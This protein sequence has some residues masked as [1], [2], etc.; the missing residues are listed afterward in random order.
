MNELK[1]KTV[2]QLRVQAKQLNEEGI[3]RA[4]QTEIARARKEELIEWLDFIEPED[5]EKTKP[6]EP[7]FESHSQKTSTA[8][9]SSVQF[10]SSFPSHELKADPKAVNKES[11]ISESPDRKLQTVTKN[12]EVPQGEMV[13][14]FLAGSLIFFFIQ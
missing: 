11:S 7:Y 12:S 3:I 5:L 10:P 8:L 6:L 1:H 4:T 13:V 2:K 14:L 9:N